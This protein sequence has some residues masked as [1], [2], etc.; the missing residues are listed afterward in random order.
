LSKSTNQQAV[1]NSSNC[2]TTFSPLQQFWITKFYLDAVNLAKCLLRCIDHV[3]E[4]IIIFLA[5]V[6]LAQCVTV[7]DQGAVIDEQVER[8]VWVELKTTTTK[9]SQRN[10]VHEG[11]ITT[12]HFNIPKLN[13]AQCSADTCNYNCN[14]SSRTHM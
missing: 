2:L 9:K 4:S 12:R 5:F 8:F 7:A 11:S 6:D 13:Q 14:Y 3:Q 1:L 10:L